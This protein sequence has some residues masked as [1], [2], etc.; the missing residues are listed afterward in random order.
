MEG[1]PW[2]QPALDL[3][4]RHLSVTMRCARRLRVVEPALAS[5]VAR[6]LAGPAG[7][8]W[9]Q[10]M[11][12]AAASWIFSAMQPSDPSPHASV[13]RRAAAT[14]RI[15]FLRAYHARFP[16]DR[17]DVRRVM[18]VA[19]AAAAG[20]Q[21][22]VL[23]WI[24]TVTPLHGYDMV[25]IPRLCPVVW[26]CRAHDNR[27]AHERLAMW[28]LQRTPEPS[29][30]L[31]LGFVWRG[32]LLIRTLRTTGPPVQVQTTGR[33]CPACAGS[34]Y[35]PGGPAWSVVTGRPGT[36]DEAAA[37]QGPRDRACPRCGVLALECRR[38]REYCRFVGTAEWEHP[39]RLHWC[40]V[41]RTV[42]RD[43]LEFQCDHCSAQYV[44]R[45]D[46]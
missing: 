42:A 4:P 45:A 3:G 29:G 41:P 43:G 16:L 21:A 36:G 32:G 15:D 19:C 40:D 34:T 31:S 2:E 46:A 33:A 27:G 18:A 5:S 8:A 22:D 37:P 28:L 17:T 13:V 35:G 10:R 23:R 14:G 6:C 26:A 20:A 1:L 24:A 9:A 39:G 7:W 25:A 38:C 11:S 12:P 30:L 44:T